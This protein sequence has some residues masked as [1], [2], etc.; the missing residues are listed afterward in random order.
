MPDASD[1]K[2]EFVKVGQFDADRYREES[3]KTKLG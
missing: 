1:D 2:E 3:R